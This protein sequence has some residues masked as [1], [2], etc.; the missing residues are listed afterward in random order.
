MAAA[1]AL[2]NLTDSSNTDTAT[3]AFV[4]TGACRRRH[5]PLEIPR[6]AELPSGV[7]RSPM[8]SGGNVA[9]IGVDNSVSMKIVWRPSRWFSL[10]WYQGMLLSSGRWYYEG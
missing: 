8:H 3:S 9:L 2:D 10:S 5:L 6:L 4:E 1:T 7:G